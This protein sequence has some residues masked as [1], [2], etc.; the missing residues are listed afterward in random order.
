MNPIKHLVVT[1]KKDFELLPLI[2][3]HNNF[4]LVTPTLGNVFYKGYAFLAKEDADKY[5]HLLTMLNIEAFYLCQ[6]EDTTYLVSST[7]NSKQTVHVTVGSKEKPATPPVEAYTPQQEE[8]LADLLDETLNKI[9]PQGAPEVDDAKK[10]LILE[11]AKMVFSLSKETNI[12]HAYCFQVLAKYK[13]D[14]NPALQELK[15]LAEKCK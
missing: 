15:E 7:R 2:V 12:Q 4:Q 8:K 14:Y 1:H 13:F 6:V 11:R 10:K 9:L 5:L 3:S